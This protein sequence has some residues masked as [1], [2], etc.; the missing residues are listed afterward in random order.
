MEQRA[1]RARGLGIGGG[2]IMRARKAC[3]GVLVVLSLTTAVGCTGERRSGAAPEKAPPKVRHD[4][5]PIASSL[6]QLGDV[7]SVEWTYEPLGVADPRVPGPTDL[8]LKG[9][10][11][12]TEADVRRLTKQYAWTE[13]AEPPPTPPPG[14]GAGTRWQTSAA[15]EAAAVSGASAE[16]AEF[17]LDPA[18]RVIVFRLLNPS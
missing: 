13:A 5:A 11:R 1:D 16:D 2:T 17:R 15:F 6:P 18:G 14:A 7:E 10:A 4:E 9:F 8:E 12:L 3:A